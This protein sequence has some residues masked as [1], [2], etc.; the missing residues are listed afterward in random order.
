M[1]IGVGEVAGFA[2]NLQRGFEDLGTPCDYLDLSE[3]PFAYGGTKALPRLSALRLRLQGRVASVGRKSLRGRTLRVGIWLVDLA[4]LSWAISRHD[5]F[6]FLG[7]RSLLRR[8][9]DLPI[10]RLVGKEVIFVFLGSD[11]RPPYLNG[12]L[13]AR[14]ADPARS[15]LDRLVA[16]T[17]ETVRTV[18]RIERHAQFVVGMSGSAHFHRRPFIHF[19]AMGIPSGQEGADD[20]LASPSQAASFTGSGVRVLHAPSDVAKGSKRIREW[21][22]L[23]RADGVEIDYLELVKRPHREVLQAIAQS[24]LVVDQLYSD[25]PLAAFA[26]EAAYLGKPVLV[27]GYY[28]GQIRDDL[29]S[30]LIPPSCFVTPEAFPAS[31]RA[32]VT[33]AGLRSEMGLRVSGYVRSRWSRSA[34]ARRYQQLIEGKP[35]PEWM[36]DP[37]NIRYVHGWG[38]EEKAL[39]DVIRSLRD[40]FGSAVFQ[41]GR[42]PSALSRLLELGGSASGR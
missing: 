23:L 28:A 15:G 1:L 17:R 32:L 31:L 3:H 40:R 19:L 26:A 25:S 14:H 27:G 42:N 37:A 12:K 4:A 36:Y 11:H 22:D 16:H 41:L 35:S 39:A 38:L 21:I 10:L 2:S 13:V 30:D 34:V 24:D 7:R 18:A 9:L 5:A 29:A 33:D 8:N 20:E 6:I